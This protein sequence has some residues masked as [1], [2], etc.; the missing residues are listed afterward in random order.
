LVYIAN[1]DPLTG[2]LNRAQFHDR[3]TQTLSSVRRHNTR[4]AVMFLDLDRFKLINDTL[5]HRI[6]DLLLQA[7]SERLKSSIRIND[8]VAR[9]GGDEFIVLLSDINHIDDVARI[10]QKTIELL[11]QPFTSRR[12]QYCGNH[13]Y[14]DQRLPRRRG[15]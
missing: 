11:A 2:L 15:Q 10:A 12:Q 3:L 8:I 13:E 4:L 5:G 7:V 9:L 14:R 6:G 1:H